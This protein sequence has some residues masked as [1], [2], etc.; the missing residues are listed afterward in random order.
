MIKELG[1]EENRRGGKVGRERKEEEETIM[2]LERLP[3]GTEDRKLIL[4]WIAKEQQ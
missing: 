3:P 1:E 2:I 4:L